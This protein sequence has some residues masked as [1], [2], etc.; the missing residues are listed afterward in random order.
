[1]EI[2]DEVFIGEVLFKQIEQLIKMYETLQKI[3]DELKI[4]LSI[5]M[6]N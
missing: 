6:K 4:N 5:Y 1:M 3:K 2:K